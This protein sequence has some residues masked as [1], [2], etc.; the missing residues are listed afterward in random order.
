MMIVNGPWIFSGAWKLIKP[1]LEERT[2]NKIS[3]M[4]SGFLP[5]LLENIDDAQLPVE[6]GGHAPAQNGPTQDTDEP[7]VYLCEHGMAAFL[8]KYPDYQ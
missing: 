2:V 6:L 1:W 5:T 4:S 7:Y 8:E 3:I